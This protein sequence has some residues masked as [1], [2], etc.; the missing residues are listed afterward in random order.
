V[1]SEVERRVTALVEG[2]SPTLLD[3]RCVGLERETL[4]VNAHG[5][6]ATSDHPRA[7]GSALCNS[8]VTTD[9]SEALVEMVTPPMD[10][11]G[12]ALQSL[13]DVHRFV[14][15]RLEN[16]E[17]LWA[18][19]MP[20]VLGGD[21]SI[22]I[23]EYGTSHAGR[24]KHA[25]RRGLGVRYGRR[26]QAIAGIHFNFSLP[27]AAW[28][29][30]GAAGKGATSPAS[31]SAGYF[32]MMQNLIGIGW[33]VPWLF[34]ASPAICRTFLTPGT[35]TDLDTFGGATLFAPHG[36]SLRMGN[37]GYRYRED[38]AIDLSVDH[39]AL[40]CWIDDVVGHVTQTHPAY[41]ELGL[42]DAHGERQQLS[43]GRL[44]IEN[45]YYGTVR[46]K[47]IPEPGEMPI[48]ALQQR[49][50]R[51]LEL[52]SLDVDPFEPSGLSLHTVAFLELMMLFAWLADPLPLDGAA[53]ERTKHNLK[54]VAHQGRDPALM[55][56]SPDGERGP[57]AWAA[58][59]LEPMRGLAVWL[60]GANGDG[61]Y[62]AALEAQFAKLEDRDRLPS[63]RVLE[64]VNEAGSFA[65]FT[66]RQSLA[67][68]ETLTETPLEP[69]R[70]SALQEQ[71]DASWLCQ[72]QLE[73]GSHGSFEDFLTDYFAPLDGVA[74]VPEADAGIGV[75]IGAGAG[76]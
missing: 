65:E 73:A 70:D 56:R 6:I 66:A 3:G 36:T 72:A 71:A 74:G 8:T 59:I 49:G 7:L 43:A 47:Q 30:R 38:S 18:A 68:H 34:G 41:A 39:R 46:P 51:Y 32:S 21:E 54:R 16:D 12:A 52:R 9:F 62:R 33:L 27:E 25:Y 23:G 4:R 50:V 10:S 13:E 60:D 44:Q 67:H 17:T 1:Y 29:W 15:A 57:A 45:E 22:R 63:A 24:M 20:C 58:D 69:S 11:A 19:S 28:A 26:M 76:E 31:M 14:S 75:G 40:Q 61:L 42:H 64:G 37:I 53:M 5:A 35:T 2:S 55:L 48:L